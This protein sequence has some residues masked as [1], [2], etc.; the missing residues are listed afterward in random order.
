MEGKRYG[1]FISAD[2]KI[3][4]N[5][6]NLEFNQIHP[7]KKVFFSD[8]LQ[9]FK[10]PKNT[11]KLYKL[12]TLDADVFCKHNEDCFQIY[13]SNIIFHYKHIGSHVSLKISEIINLN[14]LINKPVKL[15]GR[16]MGI[17]T[18]LPN[19]NDKHVEIV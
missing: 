5:H 12:Q 3:T 4:T 8:T 18:S 1:I 15:S 13:I 9:L 11:G 10:L 19:T 6:K 17:I 2:S 16:Y 7:I 14:F